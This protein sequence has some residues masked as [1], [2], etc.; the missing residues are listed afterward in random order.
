MGADGYLMIY[1]WDAICKDNMGDKFLKM[2]SNCYVET[3]KDNPFLNKN[4]MHAYFD[5]VIDLTTETRYNRKVEELFDKYKLTT[6]W[7]WKLWT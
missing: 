4:I 1:D 3:V 6:D 2:F 5:D 7:S